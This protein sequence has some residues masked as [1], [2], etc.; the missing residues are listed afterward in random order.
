MK[1]TA[2]LLSFLAF[3]FLA[4]A[5][6]A[7]V[8]ETFKQTY[9]LTADGVVHL[10][11]VNGDIDITAWD[12]AEVSLV[13]DKRARDD[14]E[15]KRIEIEIDAQPDRLAIKTKY[16]KK[17]GWFFGNTHQGSV[18]YKLMVPAGA[19]LQKIDT[20]NSDITVTGVHGAVNLDTVNGSISAS[21]LMADA[22]LDSVN[23][24]LRAEFVSLDKVQT[25]KLDSV[26]GRA[27]VTLPKGA[28]ASIKTSS[29]NGSSSVDQAIKLSHSGRHS[30]SGDIGSGG[31]R[32]TLDTVNGSIAV[33]EK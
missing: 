4:I 2:R 28:S 21:G 22:R 5:A 13:A 29:V 33:R 10:E 26:N 25:V 11:N 32:I 3:A 24:S 30:L 23:G 17:T 18:R 19:R 9:P 1:T 16:A 14:E 6:R 15:L 8:N 12:K 27:E 31:P 20:V 7:T